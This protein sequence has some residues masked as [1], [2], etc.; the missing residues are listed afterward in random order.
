MLSKKPGA[1]LNLRYELNFFFTDS[2][3]SEISYA[4]KK[5]V[6]TLLNKE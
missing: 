3:S 5:R 2:L 4:Y 1:S 6:F